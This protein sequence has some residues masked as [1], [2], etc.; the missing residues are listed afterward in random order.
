[1]IGI[2]TGPLGTLSQTLNQIVTVAT[3]S[4]SS[5]SN[6][7]KVQ[8]AAR[9]VKA[10]VLAIGQAADKKNAEAC[11]KQASLASQDLKILLEIA[12]E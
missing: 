7:S 10:D 3:T 9:K 1:M 6:T 5:K 2:V 8:E 11:T 12:F 4:A